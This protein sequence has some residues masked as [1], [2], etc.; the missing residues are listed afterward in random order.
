MDGPA[1]DGAMIQAMSILHVSTYV[2]I[3]LVSLTL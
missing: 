3:M 2:Y 1:A